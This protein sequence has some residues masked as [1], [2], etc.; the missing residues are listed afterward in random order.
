MDTDLP[1]LALAA[2]VAGLVIAV[3]PVIAT[4]DRTCAVPEGPR[5]GAPVYLAFASDRRIDELRCEARG[6]IAF[7]LVRTPEEAA[8][9]IADESVTGILL[10]RAAY[11]RLRPGEVNRWLALG[12][13]RAV[14]ALDLTGLQLRANAEGALLPFHGGGWGTDLGDSFVGHAV[15]RRT[16]AG[17]CGGGGSMPY[18]PAF[19]VGRLIAFAARCPA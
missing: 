18:R 11:A 5:P 2:F 8:T 10:D 6:G 12:T 13:G 9:R 15:F 7:E 4:R 16:T 1:R 17:T 14:V 3:L 19:L